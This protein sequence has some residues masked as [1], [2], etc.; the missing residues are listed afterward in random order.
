MH[1]K[2]V[3]AVLELNKASIRLVFIAKEDLGDFV[4]VANTAFTGTRFPT[5]TDARMATGQQLSTRHIAWGSVAGLRA[6]S[7]ALVVLAVPDTGL[8]TGAAQL[9]TLL[10]ALAVDTAVLTGPLAGWTLTNAWLLALVRADEQTLAGLLTAF[11]KSSFKTAVA[12]ARA[13]MPAGQDGVT[14]G[15]ALHRQA[16]HEV[17]HIATL[18]LLAMPTL[19]F[20]GDLF[21]TYSHTLLTTQ[22]TALVP[23]F[24]EFVAWFLAAEICLR[25]R[26][27]DHLFMVTAGNDLGYFHLTRLTLFKAFTRTPVPIWANNFLAWLPALELLV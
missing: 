2:D 10:L 14:L 1:F 4:V 3:A 19:E 15:G 7:G 16:K 24:Q 26:T 23:T 5:Q 12:G 25:H 9:P 20:L 22:T 18:H 17:F 13:R 6:E 27:R 8:H 11:M 21:C